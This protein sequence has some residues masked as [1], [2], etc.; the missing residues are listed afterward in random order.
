[1]G[2]FRSGLSRTLFSDSRIRLMHELQKGHKRT[3]TELSATISLHPNTVRE[4][5]QRLIDDGFII[6]TVETRKTRG[7]PLTFYSTLPNGSEKTPFSPAANKV[8][9]ASAKAE[10]IR[11]VLPN[12]SNIDLP[13]PIIQQLDLL[14]DHLDQLGL[15]PRVDADGCFI[16]LNS[17]MHATKMTAGTE[18]V[19]TVH[20]DLIKTTLAMIDGPLTVAE[21][22]PFTK[23]TECTI[24]LTSVAT[25][26]TAL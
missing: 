12:D 19:C 22:Q 11:R 9:Q 20:R 2:T 18:I 14:E 26:E 6:S 7:R 23:A 3:V 4:H 5:L 17:C 24:Q 25:H 13:D 21:L 16:Q 15:E 1:M 10:L 8:T